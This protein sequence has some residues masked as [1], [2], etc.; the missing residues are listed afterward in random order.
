MGVYM[1]AFVC[2][3]VCMLVLACARMA[4]LYSSEKQWDHCKKKKTVFYMLKEK[5]K[6]MEGEEKGNGTRTFS[7]N[8][9][10]N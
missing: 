2:L 3:I 1:G 7:S 10:F 5:G 4:A 6:H 9:N 8:I